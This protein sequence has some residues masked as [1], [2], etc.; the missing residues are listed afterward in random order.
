M[1]RYGLGG[2]RTAGAARPVQFGWTPY[3]VT[4]EPEKVMKKNN[5]A[6]G[7]HFLENLFVFMNVGM[8]SS[9]F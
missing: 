8:H 2:Q 3:Q 1:G 7:S 4:T 5:L 6:Q 9:S